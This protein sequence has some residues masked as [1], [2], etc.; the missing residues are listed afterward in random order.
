MLGDRLQFINNFAITIF[1]HL[2]HY[3]QFE[4][5]SVFIVFKHVVALLFIALISLHF[6]VHAESDDSDELVWNVQIDMG[7]LSDPTELVGIKQEEEI[8]F[9]GLA[10]FMDLY[11]KG[12]FIQSNKN[13]T[14][15]NNFG[16]ELGYHL[17][18][19]ANYEVSLVYKSY[20]TGFDENEIYGEGSGEVVVPELEG[21]ESRFDTAMQ[22]IR[23][24]NFTSNRLFWFDIA[25]D[26]IDGEHRGWLLDTFYVYTHQVRNW[27]INTGVGAT[28]F[29][30]K[31]NDYFYG[32]NEH[33]SR[34]FRPEYSPG[35]GYIYRLELSARYPISSSWVFNTGISVNKYSDSIY[36]SPL[37]ARDTVTR[38]KMSIGYVF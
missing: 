24:L 13:R 16:A 27:D 8:D 31:T 20:A 36:A 5:R 25:A 6:P 29:S 11:Y 35:D 37:V 23:Y 3:D 28:Y 10:I 33:E 19:E 21:I 14:I 34:A 32:V 2:I 1:Y 22:G 18:E 7:L 17:Y 38:F 4:K 9:I 12:F 15:A 30:N 26:F